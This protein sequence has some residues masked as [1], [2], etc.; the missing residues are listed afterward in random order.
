MYSGVE[1]AAEHFSTE[2]KHLEKMGR[3]EHIVRIYECGIVD[4]SCMFLTMDFCAGGSL[5]SVRSCPLILP[6]QVRA[7]YCF[8]MRFLSLSTPTLGGHLSAR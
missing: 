3:H 4:A 7:A 2:V 5:D 6:P 1:Y 8:G